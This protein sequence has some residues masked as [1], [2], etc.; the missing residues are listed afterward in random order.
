VFLQKPLI[1]SWAEVCSKEIP[2]GLIAFAYLLP[3][4][5]ISGKEIHSS[6]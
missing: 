2:D 4:A 3:A 5:A 6:L 1:R